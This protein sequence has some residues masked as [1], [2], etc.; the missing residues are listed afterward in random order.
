[1]ATASSAAAATPADRQ[2]FIVGRWQEFEG[3]SRASLLRIVAIGV[4]YIVQL[5]H[6]YGFSDQ[7]DV[8][9]QFHQRATGVAVAWTMVALAVMLCLRRQIFP[10]ALK[11]VTTACDLL[12]LTA[13]ASLGAG[14]DSPLVLAY[15]LI[16]ALAALRFSLGLVWMA[17]LG[18]MLGYWLLVGIKDGRSSQWFDAD[19][20]VAPAVQLITLVSLGLTGVVIGQVVRRVKALAAE[21]A[22]RV[23]VAG[24]A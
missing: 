2:W 3:E 19:H 5:V 24:K 15:F 7:G 16:I 21:Y 12:L 23:N 13:L 8:A 18:S 20:A 11:Y 9:G 14:P 10:S 22:Q 1:M 17:T 6:F 4:F